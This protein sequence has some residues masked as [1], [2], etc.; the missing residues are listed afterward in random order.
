MFN[1]DSFTQILLFQNIYSN[2]SHI[3][4][5]REDV[6]GVEDNTAN[7]YIRRSDHQHGWTLGEWP[8]NL[9]YTSEE[10]IT[11]PEQVKHTGKVLAV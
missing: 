7:N 3:L 2:F 10:V 11:F 1:N 6:E 9:A 8:R 4:K 5:V